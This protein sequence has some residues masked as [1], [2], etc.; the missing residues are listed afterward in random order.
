[1]HNYYQVK[2]CIIYIYVMI[3]FK[4]YLVSVLLTNLCPYFWFIHF[5]T[6]INI[7]HFLKSAYSMNAMMFFYLQW[8]ARLS[9]YYLYDLKK[10]RRTFWKLSR[11]CKIYVKHCNFSHLVSYNETFYLTNAFS[12][13]YVI[14]HTGT[15]PDG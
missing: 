4:C 9:H 10:L 15:T 7:L 2:E 14:I 11:S 3:E 1:M 8:F 5:K 13:K 12:F 6:N